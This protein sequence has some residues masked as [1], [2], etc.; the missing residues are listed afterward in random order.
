MKL[1]TYIYSIL[2]FSILNW[3][4]GRTEFNLSPT[5]DDF[6]F[7][8]NKGAEMP[9]WVQGNTSS[10]TFVILLNGGPGGSSFIYNELFKPVTD[11][12]EEQYGMVYWEQRS[13][14]STQGD[15]LPEHMTPE[16]YVEDLEKVIALLQNKYGSD[17]GIFLMGI[18]WGGYLS[19]AY[20]SKAENQLPIKG[21][22]NIVGPH[23]LA[24]TSN[25]SKV[26][27]LPF[28]QQQVNLANPEPLWQEI[29][30]WCAVNDSIYNKTTFEEFNSLAVQAE[31][32]IQ[33]SLTMEMSPASLG[34]QLSF[35]F[36]SPFNA[37]A[38]S[39]NQSNIR[40]S[41]LIELAVRQPLDSQLSNIQTPTIIFSGNFDQI[42][43]HEF[44]AEQFDLLGSLDKQ[45]FLFEKSG[46]GLIS[47]ETAQ[48]LVLTQNFIEQH[49]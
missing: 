43:P 7:L 21:W 30:D 44:L 18:S 19:A 35:V 5:A 47:N 41:E 23:N 38:L 33:D 39:T 49:R 6:F 14:G 4:C 11:P 9:I 36:T 46:H 13:S 29:I 26:K 25:V 45:I 40:D 15:F 20:L 8:K 28:A 17:V 31:L 16:Q 32:Q 1:H 12:L 10:K 27:L 2:L 34:S 3:S 37:Y 24:K 22:I 48:F 42:V